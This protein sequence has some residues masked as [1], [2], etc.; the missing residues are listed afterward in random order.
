MRPEQAV[1]AFLADK[2]SRSVVQ[3]VITYLE[4]L[5]RDCMQSG[6]DSP[7]KNVWEEYCAQVQG[8]ESVFW[9]AY[10]DTAES[11]LHDAVEKL[12]RYEKLALWLQTDSGWDWN[13]DHAEDQ[14]A[15]ELAPVA[16]DEIV[17]H[18]RDALDRAAA[19]YESETLERY[20]YGLDPD[21]E[22]V[23]EDDE[24]EGNDDAEDPDDE[25]IRETIAG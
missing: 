10:T 13:Y 8:E 12:D 20:K 1:T 19:D 15:D 14:Q 25:G 21:E 7:L 16:I 24:E 17:S 9:D 18:L 2:I 3:S 22:S 23:D 5:P 6:D 11:A 4:G